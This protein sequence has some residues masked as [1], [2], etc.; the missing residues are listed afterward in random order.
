MKTKK[1]NSFS[2]K[3]IDKKI[4]YFVIKYYWLFEK[5][6]TIKGKLKYK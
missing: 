4:K 5:N 6:I 3:E 2:T 1:N